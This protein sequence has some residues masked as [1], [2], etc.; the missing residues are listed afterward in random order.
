MRTLD[1]EV[2]VEAAPET[3]WRI[4]TDFDAFPEWNPFIVEIEGK[5]VEGERLTVR[6]QPPG[7]RGMTFR[8]RVLR[9]E[10]NRE[11][12]WLGH[13]VLPGVFDGEH[14]FQIEPG[15]AGVRFVQREQLA[16]I[17]VPFLW[18]GLD[19][20]TRAGFDAMNQALK[21]RAESGP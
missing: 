12:R 21:T 1:T 16:G 4:L 14:I 18:R 7:S 19:T 2:H 17:L 10:E 3:V 5:A 6:L 8:P 15:N 13:L 9:V 20:K 11:L